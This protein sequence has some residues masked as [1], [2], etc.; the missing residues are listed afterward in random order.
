[1]EIYI[2]QPGDTI[3]SIAIQYHISAETLIQSNALKR[4]VRLVVGQAIVITV[5]IQTYTVQEGDTLLRIAN[6]FQVSVS[7]LLRNNPS[8]STTENI[9]P[10]ETIVIRYDNNKGTITTNGYAYPFIDINILNKTLPFLTY[11]TV[12]N[13]QVTG[14]GEIISYEDDTDMLES[15]RYFGVAPILLLTT[16]STQGQENYGVAISILSNEDYQNALIHNVIGLLEE[17]GYYGVNLAFQFIEQS[18]LS[19]Y[20]NFL[21]NVYSQLHPL[22]YLVFIT[23]RPAISYQD[24]DI[25]Y[26]AVDYSVFNGMNDGIIILSYEWGYSEEPPIAKTLY[27]AR[28]FLDYMVN[29]V[30]SERVSTG[31]NI[32]GYDWALPYERG[33]SQAYALNYDSV[34]D[35]AA[36]VGAVIMFDE[37]SQAPFFTYSEDVL[38]RTIQHIVWFKDARSIN[39]TMDIIR[40][41]GLQGADIWNIMYFFAEMWL[42]INTQYQIIK[43]LPEQIT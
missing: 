22:G 38:G 8:L 5:P 27:I 25:T 28:N 21:S 6:G 18:N 24:Q 42:V 31:I 30:P 40:G 43:R 3:E 12:Y 15:A 41:Y 35:L 17:K 16:F 14:E 34:L 23:V 11:L 19:L 2:V 32:L 33:V 1:M 39:A 29:L 20:Y 4:P 10:G 36:D 9:Y 26:E 37:M 7:Q 13:Y